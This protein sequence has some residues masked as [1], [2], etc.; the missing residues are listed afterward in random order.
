MWDAVSAISHSLPLFPLGLLFAWVKKESILSIDI[1]MLI[2][3]KKKK[4]EPAKSS[5]KERRTCCEQ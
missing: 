3:K 1:R 4:K 5:F 2:K